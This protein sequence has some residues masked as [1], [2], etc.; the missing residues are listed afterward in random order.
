MKSEDRWREIAPKF[1]NSP[2]TSEAPYGFATRVVA[3]ANL[4]LPR[5]SRALLLWRRYSLSMAGA[6]AILLGINFLN[7]PSIDQQFLPLPEADFSIS[8]SIEK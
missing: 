4:G 5:Q 3:A 6:A 8:H 2:E 7:Q 1:R